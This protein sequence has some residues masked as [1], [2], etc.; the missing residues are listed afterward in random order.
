M[1]TATE[2]TVAAAP[3]QD[4]AIAA[5]KWRPIAIGLAVRL[6]GL[7]FIWLGDGHS[8]LFHKAL[9]LVGVVLSVGGV[10]VLRYLLITGLFKK[11]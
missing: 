8:D 4:A 6:A 10:A 7:A 2:S 9:V 5:T 3:R 11:K 1:D